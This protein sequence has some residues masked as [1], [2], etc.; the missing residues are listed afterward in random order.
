[1]K[2]IGN[3]AYWTILE[4]R[5]LR[6]REKKPGDAPTATRISALPVQR[7]T[8]I[9]FIRIW[10]WEAASIEQITHHQRSEL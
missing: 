9:A 1:M 3:S 4:A 7:C 5:K 6:M 10:D 2:G 8:D